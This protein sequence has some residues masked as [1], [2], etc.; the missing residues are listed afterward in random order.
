MACVARSFN[1]QCSL[2]GG[3][4]C[5]VE[6]LTVLWSHSDWTSLPLK[7]NSCMSGSDRPFRCPFWIRCNFGPVKNFISRHSHHLVN[8]TETQ[9]I[10]SSQSRWLHSLN[11]AGKN[12]QYFCNFIDYFVAYQSPRWSL[13]FGCFANQQSKTQQSN[14]HNKNQRKAAN[15]QMFWGWDL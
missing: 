4:S 5:C 8:T 10:V 12:Q 1:C 6:C 14:Y 2:I 7:I 13:Q 15:P 3:T 9:I 11:R